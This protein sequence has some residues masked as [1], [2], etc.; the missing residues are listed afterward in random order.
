MAAGQ[1]DEAFDD[2][3]GRHDWAAVARERS[4]DVFSAGV[5]ALDQGDDGTGVDNHRL[6]PARWVVAEDLLSLRLGDGGSVGEQ[7]PDLASHDV[8]GIR[9]PSA[10]YLVVIASTIAMVNA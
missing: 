1:D 5:F 4:C 8:G 6:R 2:V 3:R 7:W 9:L 10:A